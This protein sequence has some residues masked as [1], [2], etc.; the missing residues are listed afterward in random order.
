[1]PDKFCIVSIDGGGL[2]GLVAIKVLQ[3]IE[4][5]SGASVL[6][7]FNLLAGTSTGGLIVCALASAR[8]QDG[9]AFNLGKIEEM[10]MEVGQEL[11]RQGG[12][13]YSARDVQKLHDLL[14]ATFGTNKLSDTRKPVFV[15]T[16]D[17]GR[18]KLV[19][20]KTRS[21]LSNPDKD[22]L[23]TDVC[24]ATT[25]IPPV[26]PPYVMQYHGRQM[27]C[28]D[29]GPYLKN[30]ALSALAEL[31]KHKSWYASQNLTE[32]NV[33]LLSVSTG[34]YR[35]NAAHWSTDIGEILHS[36]EMDMAYIES[37]DLNIDFH[38]INYMRV[39]MNLGGSAFS[40]ME[41]LKW[42]GQIQ[43]LES[44]IGFNTAVRNLLVNQR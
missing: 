28:F 36:Q 22:A 39:D 12:L 44:D 43:S 42:L 5:I 27:R 41:I 13:S 2:K 26:F 31:W 25:A 14:L 15:P 38:K 18:K 20:F 32:E 23:L 8:A 6:E 19:V 21:A 30:P 29:A 10:Y 1:M 33:T 7:Q 35:Q 3:M 34:S 24:R 37:Q 11:F 17:S 9:A 16:F 4:K 40:L